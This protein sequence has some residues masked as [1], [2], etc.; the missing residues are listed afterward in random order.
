MS[1]LTFKFALPDL[2]VAVK[3][4]RNDVH[5][6]AQRAQCYANVTIRHNPEM[7]NMTAVEGM[8]AGWREGYIAAVNDMR[9]RARKIKGVSK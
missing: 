3:L 1:E 7:A 8:K 9:A 6:L 5:G 4:S 2:D